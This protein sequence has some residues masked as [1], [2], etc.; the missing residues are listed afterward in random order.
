MTGNDGNHASQGSGSHR[1][2]EGIDSPGITPGGHYS[3]AMVAGGFVY[4]SG[5]LPCD[6]ERKIIGDTIEEQT[7]AAL[8]K[9][10]AVLTSAGARLDQVVKVNVYLSDLSLFSRVDAAYATY[11]GQ[12]RPARTTVQSDLRGMPIEID[13]VAYV[14]ALASPAA[15]PAAATGVVR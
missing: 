5:Q 10:A 3:S 4:V 6:A 12:H 1:A 8:R 9:V 15:A 13:A 11:F 7:A 2:L 14:G